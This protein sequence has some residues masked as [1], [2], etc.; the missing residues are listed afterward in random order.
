MQ[1]RIIAKMISTAWAISPEWM[2]TLMTVAKRG[3][4]IEAVQAKLGKPLD[5]TRSSTV[6]DGVAIIPVIGPIIPRA[7]LFSEVSGLTS[8]EQVMQD[9]Q[10]AL[11]NDSVHS[12]ILN[13]DTPGGAVPGIDELYTYI[14]NYGKP[15]YAYGYGTMASAGYWVASGAMKIAVSPTALIG[16]I[17]VVNGWRKDSSENDNE[18]V[19]VS[20]KSPNKRLRSADRAGAMQVIVDDIAEVFIQSVAEGRETTVDDVEENYGQGGVLVG[21]KA[22]DIG[23]VDYVMSFEEFFAKVS[24][25]SLNKIKLKSGSLGDMTALM[26]SKEGA[27]IMDVETLKAEHRVV[28][29]AVY[30]AGVDSTKEKIDAKDAE[31]AALR[32]DLEIANST[33]ADLERQIAIRAEKD[34]E[35][36]AANMAAE[37]LSKSGIPDRLHGKVIAAVLYTKYIVDGKLD[38]EAFSAALAAE[39]GEWSAV[40]ANTPGA[41]SPVVGAGAIGDGDGAVID[42]AVERLL[43]HIN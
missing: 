8:T 2:D 33:K 13:M 12:V 39:I 38:T 34:M 41:V 28:Y 25:G 32:A 15:V 35:A 29:D 26:G 43:A 22:L 24:I 11:E 20:A 42:Q 40:F 9:M 17:G 18:I 7:S 21:G 27:I 10:A 1:E 36:I 3:N 16:S 6:R 5:F 14:R 19:I 4:D 23:M 30:A 31:N 37:Q